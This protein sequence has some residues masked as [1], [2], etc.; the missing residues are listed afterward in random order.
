MKL[1]I[2]SNS[3]RIR[4]T[5]TEVSTLVNTGYL[6]DQ[7][8]FP[9]NSFTYALQTSDA[10]QLSASFTDNK[11]TLFIPA[12]WILHWA[13]ND[14]VGFKGSMPV[15]NSSLFLLVEKDFVCLDE[16]TED[17][18]DNFENPKSAC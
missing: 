15:G 8:A 4:L 7:T 2:K 16:T 1:R 3:L 11:I 9:G 10:D 13:D 14:T 18:S 5:K 6:E 17:Q 12:T